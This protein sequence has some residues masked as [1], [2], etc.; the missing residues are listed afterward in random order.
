MQTKFGHLFEGLSQIQVFKLQL[1]KE[2]GEFCK[3]YEIKYSIT[4]ELLV[5]I[6]KNEPI[7]EYLHNLSVVM[8]PKNYFKY[9]DR[10]ENEELPINRVIENIYSNPYY[11]V[12]TT[13][14]IATDTL[15]TN[16]IATPF[17]N[18]GLYITIKMVEVEKDEIAKD[19]IRK[20]NR[21][22]VGIKKLSKHLYQP[23][24]IFAYPFVKNVQNRMIEQKKHELI[25]DVNTKNYSFYL[26]GIKESIS[27][28][29]DSFNSFSKIH[30][31]DFEFFVS[32]YFLKLGVNLHPKI[33]LI[34]YKGKNPQSYIESTIIDFK[35]YFKSRG[36]KPR[37]WLYYNGFFDKLYLYFIRKIEKNPYSM[38]RYL[39]QFAFRFYLFKF[40]KELFSKKENIKI[41]VEN[42]QIEELSLVLDSYSYFFDYFYKTI[43]ELLVFDEDIFR[44]YVLLLKSQNKVS[45]AENLEENYLQLL[46]KENKKEF[47]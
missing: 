18:N 45:Y 27:I 34:K 16:I 40:K 17:V 28:E 4:D 43:N 22:F 13:R 32:D 15:A 24:K 21:Y 5:A 37:I 30:Y 39:K 8:T 2:F 42:N 1:L 38:N 14:Y 29:K 23:F 25:L 36:K 46:E 10:V 6:L 9:L 20:Q 7:K 31:E 47:L 26:K 41:L 3:K 33:T 35:T 19:S 44:A 12:K 11:P